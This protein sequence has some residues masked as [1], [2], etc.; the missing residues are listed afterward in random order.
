MLFHRSELKFTDISETRPT[1]AEL[2]NRHSSV[3]ITSCSFF[4]DCIVFKIKL[5]ERSS[6]K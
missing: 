5:A 6:V 3:K 2:G 4:T 1:E